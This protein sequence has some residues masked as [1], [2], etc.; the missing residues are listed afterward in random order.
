MW[1][2]WRKRCIKKWSSWT[3]KSIQFLTDQ[4]EE[5]SKAFENLKND[6]LQ[7]QKRYQQQQQQTSIP[8]SRKTKDKYN[9]LE[10]RSRRNNLRINGIIEGGNESRAL[11]EKKLQEIIKDQLQF[12]RYNEIERVHRCEKTMIDWTTNKRRTIIAEFLN[13]KDKQEVLSKYK[14]RQL[15]TKCMEK[16]KGLFERAKKL[17]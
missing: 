14:A 17:L 6:L 3:K 5:N 9:N 15:W 12:E 2:N 1:I 11:S 10:N 16:G 4:W 7:N 8:D 13:F